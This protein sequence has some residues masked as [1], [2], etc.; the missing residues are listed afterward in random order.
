MCTFLTACD[1]LSSGCNKLTELFVVIAW[2]YKIENSGTPLFLLEVSF[3][4]TCR[5][6]FDFRAQTH[7]FCS[8]VFFSPSLTTSKSNKAAGSQSLLV[9]CWLSS[10]T[11][12]ITFE[13]PGT[14][15]Q[16]PY[17]ITMNS[18]LTLLVIALVIATASAFS[19]HTP[20]SGVTVSFSLKRNNKHHH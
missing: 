18:T 4:T 20:M 6:L 9:A 14:L 19:V 3:I 15:H 7:L 12:A 5:L 16:V 17:T 11:T 13:Q 1:I 10:S 2:L 8:D